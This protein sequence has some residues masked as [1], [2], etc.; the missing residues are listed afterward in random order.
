MLTPERP[1]DAFWVE[2]S[3]AEAQRWTPDLHG[4]H[5]AQRERDPS[6]PLCFL[7]TR[8]AQHVRAFPFTFPFTGLWNG[9]CPFEP[10]QPVTITDLRELADL[11][12]Q[13]SAPFTPAEF[14]DLPSLA[15]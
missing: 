1:Q 5:Q 2:C 8:E 9:F 11:C 15:H 3:P 4:P 10:V 6:W 7:V 14:G 13:A 12:V